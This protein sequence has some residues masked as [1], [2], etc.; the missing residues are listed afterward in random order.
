[1]PKKVQYYQNDTFKANYFQ[2]DKCEGNYRYLNKT[3][4]KEIIF[5]I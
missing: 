3:K 1:M 2:C 4:K 5:Q